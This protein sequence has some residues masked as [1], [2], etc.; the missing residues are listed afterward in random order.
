MCQMQNGSK[1]RLLAL[2][3]KR[4]N[5]FMIH[6][7]KFSLELNWKSEIKRVLWG[8]IFQVMYHN[9]LGEECGFVLIVEFVSH[10]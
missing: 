10:L 9:S 4:Y 6:F 3:S 2:S 8:N 5:F 7:I 1:F